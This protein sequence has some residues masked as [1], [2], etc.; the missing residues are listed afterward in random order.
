LTTPVGIPELFAGEDGAGAVI[1]PC[2]RY[3]YA[4]WRKWSTELP[5]ACFVML[6]P[7]IADAKKNDPTI[8]K[9]MGFAA[10]WGC[11]GIR[12]VNLFAFRSTDPKALAKVEDPIGPDNNNWIEDGIWWN[13]PVAAWGSAGGSAVAR[14]VRARLAWLREEEH[15]F[16]RCLG[17]SAD[18]S[19]RHPLMLAYDTPLGDFTWP[20]VR[21]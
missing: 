1:S 13:Q 5:I 19:P 21:T 7:S 11:G 16:L 15:P 20:E 4:L 8:R 3:R 2:G 9:C 17:K 14:I 6:N 18:G 12:V 10:R